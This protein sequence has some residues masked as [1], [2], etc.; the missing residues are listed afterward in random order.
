LGGVK[1]GK[2]KFKPTFYGMQNRGQVMP[3]VSY[4]ILAKTKII[5]VLAVS[6]T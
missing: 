6:N 4:G 5:L 3:M 1:T 2:K